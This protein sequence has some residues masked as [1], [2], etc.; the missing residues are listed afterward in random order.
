MKAVIQQ[1]NWAK[2]SAGGAVGW[3]AFGMQYIAT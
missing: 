3:H 1:D 2:V